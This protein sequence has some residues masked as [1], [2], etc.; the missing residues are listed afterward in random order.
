MGFGDVKAVAI[1]SAIFSGVHYIP[2]YGDAFG[3]GSFTFRFL[4]GIMFLV[5]LLI[6]L[7]F[8]AFAI[9]MMYKA[10]QNEL[11]RAPIIGDLAAKQALV[12]AARANMERLRATEGFTRIVA[13][14]DGIVTARDTNVGQ[15]IQAGGGTGHC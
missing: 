9:F 5:S 15:L 2:P 12:K 11:F 3:L 6:H 13:P 7:V 8:F 14:F 4:A 1:T 10:Y